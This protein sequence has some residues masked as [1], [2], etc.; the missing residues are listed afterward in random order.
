MHLN[1]VVNYR[2]PDT[3][4]HRKQEGENGQQKMCNSPFTG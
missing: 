2:S 1:Q 4:V 3:E